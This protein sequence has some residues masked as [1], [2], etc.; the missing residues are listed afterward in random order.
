M[1][2]ELEVL[3][4]RFEWDSENF[5]RGIRRSQQMLRQFEQA[6]ARGLPMQQQ[7]GRSPAVPAGARALRALERSLGGGGFRAASQMR[8]A[9]ER[10]DL[11]FRFLVGEGSLAHYLDFCLGLA[12]RGHSSDILHIRRRLRRR[13]GAWLTDR[14][15]VP[16][17]LAQYGLLGRPE[18][19]KQIACD[20]RSI[21]R[22]ELTRHLVCSVTESLIATKRINIPPKPRFSD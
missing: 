9:Q 17:K 19:L 6:V 20:D 1:V 3:R 16:L 10:L 12:C 13:C 11:A 21:V 22:S 2:M 8:V 7:I 4:Q 5:D 15:T 14:L 18:F